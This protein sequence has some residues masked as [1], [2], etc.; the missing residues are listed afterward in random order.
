MYFAESQIR[1]VQARKSRSLR[2]L[3]I[4]ATHT[5]TISFPFVNPGCTG[6]GDGAMT[7]G[8]ESGQGQ[9]PRRTGWPWRKLASHGL[10]PSRPT[11]AA[12]PSMFSHR[13]PIELELCYMCI[14]T[15]QHARSAGEPLM[16]SWHPCYASGPRSRSSPVPT[17]RYLKVDWD[18][19]SVLNSKL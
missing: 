17:R 13:D 15:M 1:M 4:V 3:D 8:A 19:S 2:T 7:D 18:E 12:H 5:C 16:S 6:E 9:V 11:T 14:T 10:S